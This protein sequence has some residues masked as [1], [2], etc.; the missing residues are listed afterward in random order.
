MADDFRRAFLRHLDQH[1]TSLAALARETGVSLDVLKKLKTRATGS[2][3]AENAMLIS[4]YYGKTVNQF[5]AGDEVSADQ[6]FAN[7][8]QMLTPAERQLLEAQM[9]GLIYSLPM[10]CA[11]AP[12]MGDTDET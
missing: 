4:A 12:T 6:T 3:T 9:R 2:T 11:P 7:L 10:P 5:I 1:G 8:L